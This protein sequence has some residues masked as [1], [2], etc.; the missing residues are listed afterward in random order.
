[1]S[2]DQILE[3]IRT[4]CEDVFKINSLKIH[5]STTPNDI[6]KWDSL[7]HAILISKIENHFQIKFELM[8]MFNFESIGDICQG[9]MQKLG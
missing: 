4:I 7:N 9:I 3:Q 5:T 1:M 6:S 8:D 2:E